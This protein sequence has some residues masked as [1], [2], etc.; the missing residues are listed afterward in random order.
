[1][2]LKFNNISLKEKNKYLIKDLNLDISS[3]NIT[4]VINDKNN[5]IKKILVDKLEI[6][7]EVNLKDKVVSYIN[8][9]DF[10][11]KTVSDEFYLIKNKVQD[12][13]NY[14]EKI[15]LSLEM[16]GITD[17]Y[18]DRC[19]NTLSRTEKILVSIALAL[20]IN[21]D[22]IIF[23]G[24]FKN[25]DRK[26]KLT[27][28]K[29]ILELKRKYNKTIILI[30]DINIL[31]EV[32]NSYIIFKDDYLLISGNRENVFN[33]ELLRENN[34][35]LPFFIEF[36]NEAKEFNKDIKY[37]QDINDLLKGVYKNAR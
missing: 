25:L 9:R 7:G 18:L 5:V 19:I 20:I 27:I 28:K 30:D 26:N 11:T 37:Y 36:S 10:L 29:I 32:C 16:V 35:E 22:I 24:I 14:I 8:K 6:E 34:I 23:D 3:K 21:P 13:E 33:V 12:K 2:D 31:Y 4:G 15:L 17:N 1:M